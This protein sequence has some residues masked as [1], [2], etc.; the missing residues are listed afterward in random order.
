M[1][2]NAHKND[3]LI[4]QALVTGMTIRESAEIVGVN[5]KTVRRRLQD[6]DFAGRLAGHRLEITRA[7]LDRMVDASV[8]AVDTLKKL[9]S[10]KGETVRLGAA[11]AIIELGAKLQENGQQA[12]R[13]AELEKVLKEIQA[14]EA[15]RSGTTGP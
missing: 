6:P 13:L 8:D 10:A 1:S 2:R 5:E 11:R 14:N 3:D 12:E 4:L 7:V 15:E 9:L